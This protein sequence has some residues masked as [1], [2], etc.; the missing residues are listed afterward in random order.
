M[1]LPDVQSLGW[2]S[3]RTPRSVSALPLVSDLGAGETEVLMLA[4]ESKDPLVLLDDG[5][6]RRVAKT[7]SLPAKGT[8]GLLLDGK[9]RG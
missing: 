1:D 3:V 2:L 5:L 7:L 6:A 8:L 9:R 4:L